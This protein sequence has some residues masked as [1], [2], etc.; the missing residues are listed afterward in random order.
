MGK[1]PLGWWSEGEVWCERF[2]FLGGGSI[3]VLEKL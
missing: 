3:V 2:S 1:R